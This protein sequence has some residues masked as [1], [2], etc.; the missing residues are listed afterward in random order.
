MSLRPLHFALP[1]AYARI[2]VVQSIRR[3]WSPLYLTTES[4][5]C[6][7]GIQP[8]RVDAAKTKPSRG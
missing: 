3:Y 5:R 6:A 7:G 2:K 1:P 8:E 4:T